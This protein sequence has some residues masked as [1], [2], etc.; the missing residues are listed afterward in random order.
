MCISR[1]TNACACLLE[2]IMKYS[3]VLKLTLISKS[4]FKRR[5][6]KAILYLKNKKMKIHGY[7]EV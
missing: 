6:S 5:K 2:D 7:Q 4:E 3:Q 1:Y